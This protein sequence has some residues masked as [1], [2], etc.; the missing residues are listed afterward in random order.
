MQ[1][2]RPHSCDQKI[3]L[4]YDNCTVHKARH[5]REVIDECGFVEMEH[6]PYSPDLVPS[7]YYLFPKLKKYLR[8]RRFSS[9]E[10]LKK[11]V[12]EFF[13]DLSKKK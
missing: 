5:I 12:E 3:M 4:L 13:E 7:D 2:K 11:A 6:P 9:D 8:G 1:Q 10:Y